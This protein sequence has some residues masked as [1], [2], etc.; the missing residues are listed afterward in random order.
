MSIHSYNVDNNILMGG[1]QIETFVKH[2]RNF[3]ILYR[4]RERDE[5]KKYPFQS[6]G[7]VAGQGV[8]LWL[9]YN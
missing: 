7:A 8:I 1:S 3:F 4:E 5:R 2:L 9:N 6:Q